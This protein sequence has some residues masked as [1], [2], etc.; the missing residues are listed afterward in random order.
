MSIRSLSA[1]AVAR[2]AAPA[3]KPA[4]GGGGTAAVTPAGGQQVAAASEVPQ[5]FTDVLVSAIPT[6]PLTAYTALVGITVG[7]VDQSKPQSYLAFRWWAYAVFLVVVLVA[8]WVAYRRKSKEATTDPKAANP[9]PLSFPWAEACAAL[10]AAGGW[11]L[12]MP[13]SPL[14]AQLTGTPRTLAIA[15]VVI[16]VAALLTLAFAPQLKVGTSTKI[17][18]GQ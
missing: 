16:G 7:A 10:L 5:S 14:N 15:T 17:K 2:D 12:A 13:G 9:R 6:E 8:V 3:G 4:G 11:G 1:L 18:T